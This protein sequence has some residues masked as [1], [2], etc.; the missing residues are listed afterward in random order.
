VKKQR[1]RRLAAGATPVRA[2]FFGS[3]RKSSLRRFLTLCAFLVF[4]VQLAPDSQ[5]KFFVIWLL[6]LLTILAAI[7]QILE[8]MNHAKET[9][10]SL[11]GK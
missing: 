10:M 4:S 9:L 2:T 3:M 11:L 5:I 8:D 6:V 7:N 1:N